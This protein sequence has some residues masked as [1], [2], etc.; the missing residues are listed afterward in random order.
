MLHSIFYCLTGDLNCRQTSLNWN[1]NFMEHFSCL[2][3]LLSLKKY[4]LTP[5]MLHSISSCLT[6]DL[7]YNKT[8][9]YTLYSMHFQPTEYK[10]VLML[11]IIIN[12]VNY[13]LAG[14]LDFFYKYFYY[15][16]IYVN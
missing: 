6:A 14:L 13:G 1:A 12:T 15:L 11:V 5:A 8:P 10:Q 3:R 9:F 7:E 16:F 4:V 2:K